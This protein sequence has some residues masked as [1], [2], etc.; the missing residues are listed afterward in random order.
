VGRR[1]SSGC[2][3]VAECPGLMLVLALVGTSGDS[4]HHTMTAGTAL[5]LRGKRGSRVDSA[6]ATRLEE[7]QR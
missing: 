3:G 2:P 4:A 1:D 7:D 5:P 6:L